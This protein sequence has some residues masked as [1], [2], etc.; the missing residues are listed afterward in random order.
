MTQNPPLTELESLQARA[1]LAGWTVEQ[2]EDGT[3]LVSRWGLS[4]S[5][6]DLAAVAEFLR[7][8]GVRDG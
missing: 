6:P 3:F 4:R 5:L 2:I 7:R 8:A 1:L